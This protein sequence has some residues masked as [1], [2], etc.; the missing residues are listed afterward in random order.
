MKTAT[1]LYVVGEGTAERLVR[2]THPAVALT[3]ATR[4]VKVKVASQD[5]LVRLIAAGVK[6]ELARPVNGELDV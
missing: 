2:A 3:F 1:R 5:D 6:P 4:D